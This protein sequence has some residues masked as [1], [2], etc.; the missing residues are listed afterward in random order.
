MRQ[1]SRRNKL[2]ENYVP[3]APITAPVFGVA[4][5]EPQG[6]AAQAAHAHEPSQGPPGAPTEASV[7]PL[8]S[9]PAEKIVKKPIPEE[10]G[11]LKVV[12]DG[13]VQRCLSASTDPQTKRK[14]DDATK[15]LEYLYDKLREQTLSPHILAGLHEIA[16]RV[17]ARDYPQGLAVHTQ[18]VSS[19]NFSEISAFMPV[20]KV[21]VTIAGKLNI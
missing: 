4:P 15:R 2:P 20:L 16:R 11:V 10:H 8:Q 1:G 7:Q 17:E 13:L 18:V 12:F 21:V 6:G 14:L 9:L 5:L 19:S 3:P